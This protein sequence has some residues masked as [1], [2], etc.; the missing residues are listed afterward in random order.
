MVSEVVGVRIRVEDLRPR[1]REVLEVLREH[2]ERCRASEVL[3]VKVRVYTD[4][5]FRV[6]DEYELD[7]C[8][9]D[10]ESECELDEYDFVI[11]PVCGRVIYS[12]YSDY[13]GK[14]YRELPPPV[15]EYVEDVLVE[16]DE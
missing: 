14:S 4:S 9:E 8:G 3:L 15:S 11:C 13:V 5:L 2:M 16:D 7:I 6:G 10:Y 12:P 1:E